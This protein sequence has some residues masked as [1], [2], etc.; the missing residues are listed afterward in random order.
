MVGS[1]NPGQWEARGS[2]RGPLWEGLPSLTMCHRE[3][4]VRCLPPDRHGGS[5]TPLRPF[6]D[7]ER[8]MRQGAKKGAH[9]EGKSPVLVARGVPGLPSWNSPNLELWAVCQINVFI[10]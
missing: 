6:G 10:V 7:C 4:R 5:L 3:E 8:G 2:L 9:K 1:G